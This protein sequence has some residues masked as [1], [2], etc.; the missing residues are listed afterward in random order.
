VSLAWDMK[1]TLYHTSYRKSKV[2]S[3]SAKLSLRSSS[4]A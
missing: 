2:V 3:I 4:K 1:V